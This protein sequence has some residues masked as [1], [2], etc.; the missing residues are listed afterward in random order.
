MISRKVRY[1]ISLKNNSSKNMLFMNYVS[2]I[3][4][5]YSE[6]MLVYYVCALT[7]LYIYICIH[8]I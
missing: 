2:Q 8:I 7:V 1:D 3:D 6:Y 5:S 4:N